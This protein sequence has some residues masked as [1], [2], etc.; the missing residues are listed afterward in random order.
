MKF[1][2]NDRKPTGASRKT[3]INDSFDESENDL[4]MID[5]D[6]EF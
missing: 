6:L 3:N 5:D 2:E 1:S 4:K